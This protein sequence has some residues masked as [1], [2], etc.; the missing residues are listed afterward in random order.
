MEYIKV[1]AVW[2]ILLH[3]AG[4]FDVEDD[5]FIYSSYES[6]VKEI[7]KMNDSRAAYGIEDE[8]SYVELL[9]EHEKDGKFV[10]FKSTKVRLD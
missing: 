2:R 6:A 10:T 3:F 7:L 1:K 4:T 8:G 5:G 9:E